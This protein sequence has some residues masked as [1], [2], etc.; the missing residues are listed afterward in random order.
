M[1]RPKTHANAAMKNRIPV[2]PLRL[3]PMYAPSAENPTVTATRPMT[4]PNTARV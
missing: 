3:R 4:W 2:P 1:F